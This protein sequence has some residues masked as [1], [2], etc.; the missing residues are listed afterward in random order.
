MANEKNIL[1]ANLFALGLVGAGGWWALKR[2]ARWQIQRVQSRAIGR[3]MSDPYD[4]N[5]WEFYSGLK[6]SGLQTVVETSLRA[7]NG[8]VISRPL[9]TPRNFPG[10]ERLLF[11]FAFLEQL[12]TPGDAAVDLSATLGP[13]A[14][15]PL[16]LKM[17]VMVSGMAYGV[18]M[19]EKAK[20]ALAKG[21]ARAG[22]ATNTGE[23]PFLVSE[24]KA[25]RYLIVQYNRGTWN[26]SFDILR[27]ADAI[28]I[29]LGQ[30]AIGGIGHVLES[31]YID[32]HL[33][34]QYG[35]RPGT[36]AIIHA[37]HPGMSLKDNLP[38]MVNMLRRETGGIPIGA[39]LGAGKYL[40]RDLAILIDAGVD[41]VCL[42]GAQAATKGSPPILQDDFGVPAL[43]AVARAADFLQKNGLK[44]KVSLVAAGGFLT[45]GQFLKAIAL[46]ADLVYIATVALYAMSH[47]QVFKALPWEP[48]TQL[49]FYDGH[50]AKKLNV[51]QA[52]LNLGN[53]LNSCAGEMR[54]GIRALGKTSLKEVN[55]SDLMA[56]D[57]ETADALGIATVYD[58]AD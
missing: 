57:R 43:Y 29:Q 32:R 33:R 41:Y 2:M 45:P 58:P 44:G 21:S 1:P 5:L 27:Q 37:R 36:P 49:I 24:R 8:K 53:F 18:A 4:E 50:Q 55:R 15:R 28:E 6:R 46:G 22:T 48:P 16:T 54:Q 39:K 19:S 20:V 38:A 11:N 25:A 23:G 31:R 14:K 34:R 30:G 3:I 42:D 56:V 52:A 47:K 35:L 10:F 13:Q 9:G 7:T 26:K 40:E 17:P 51:N 12:P